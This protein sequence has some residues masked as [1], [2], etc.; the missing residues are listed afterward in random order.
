MTGHVVWI[1][2]PFPCGAF[3]DIGMFRPAQPH[4]NMLNDGEMVIEL[5]P[6]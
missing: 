4:A 3:S 6:F 1:N 2:G 5:V